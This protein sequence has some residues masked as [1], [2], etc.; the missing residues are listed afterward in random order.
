MSSLVG[1][2]EVV[3][4]AK[5]LKIRASSFPIPFKQCCRCQQLLYAGHVGRYEVPVGNHYSER[6]LRAI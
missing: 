4:T 1:R 3:N 6:F 2:G 5:I